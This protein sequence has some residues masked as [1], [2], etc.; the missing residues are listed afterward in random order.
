MLKITPF[1]LTGLRALKCRLEAKQGV[2][3]ISDNASVHT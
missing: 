2:T 3:R 1:V